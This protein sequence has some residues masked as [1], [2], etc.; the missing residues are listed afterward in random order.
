[1]AKFAP[2]HAIASTS[3]TSRAFYEASPK[4]K[5]WGIGI[6]VKQA[7][8]GKLHNGQNK[9]GRALDRARA[10]IAAMSRSNSHSC[11]QGWRIMTCNL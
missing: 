6:S 2:T 5:I 1:M 10:R 4:D 7:R 8:E 3:W 11:N 9:L